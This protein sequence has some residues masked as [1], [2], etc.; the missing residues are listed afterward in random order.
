MIFSLSMLSK[1][2]SDK[3]SLQVNVR[4]SEEAYNKLQET[5]AADDRNPTYVARKLIERGLADI[6]TE[7]ASA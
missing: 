5:A 1:T 2:D 4:L 6:N 7:R 3:K